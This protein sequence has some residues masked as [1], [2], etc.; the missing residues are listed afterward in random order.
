MDGAGQQ[1]G[2]S[3]RAGAVGVQ[4]HPADRHLPGDHGGRA[5][6]ARHAEHDGVPLGLYVRASLA[7]A[8]DREA[9]ELFEVTTAA[10]DHYH[11]L[12]GIRYPFGKYDQVFAPE[13]SWG[14]MEFPGCVLIRD[15]LMFRSAVTDAERE[16]RAVLIA[17]EMAHMWFGNLVTMRWWDDLWLNES[18]AD[19][20]GWRVVAEATRWRGAWTTYS[21]VRKTWAYA[22]DQRPSS[23]P[24]AATGVTDTDA[25]LVNFDGISYAKGSAV[26]RQLVAAIGDD[27]FRAGLR[28]YFDAH[29]YGNATLSDLLAALSAAAGRDL[30][31]WAEVWLR[32]AQVNTLTPEVEPLPRAGA[33][34]WCGWCSRRR[35]RTPSC[36]RT[37]SGW[38]GMRTPARR[39]YASSSSRSTSTR[40]GTTAGPPWRGW[41]GRRQGC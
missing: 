4:P 34:R 24:V 30:T 3:G 27:A 16:R 23:H 37:G 39:W 29:A 28:A 8:L 20:L 14:A 2:H 12:F 25:A 9:D 22:A 18:F 6:V 40:S 35:R 5:I 7:E 32:T 15:E 36:G 26:L 17:H 1:S 41:P 33:T 21:V 13:F 10:L 19:Y 38:G 11:R 31:R